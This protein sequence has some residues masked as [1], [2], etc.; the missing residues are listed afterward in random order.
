[1]DP[2]ADVV[3]LGGGLFGSALAYH[4]AE[5]T[6]LRVTLY[7][8]GS[9]RSATS[10]AAGILTTVGWDPWD[11][12]LVRYSAA[13]IAAVDRSLG[14]AAFRRAGGLRLSRT[15]AGS[16]WLDRVHALLAAE[17][18]SARLLGPSEV[19]DLAP[20]VDVDAVRSGLVTPDDATFDAAGAAQ[21]YRRLAERLGAEVVGDGAARITHDGA[22]WVVDTPQGA[23]VAPR[24][25]VACGAETKALLVTAG[26]PLPVAPFRSQ[27]AV[28]RPRPLS[29]SFPTLHDLDLEL[30]VREAPCG[31]VL[32]GNGTERR[33]TDPRTAALDADAEWLADLSARLSAIVPTWDH[34]VTERSWAGC[35]V[36]SPDRFP[37]VGRIPGAP[38]LL[39]ATGF[40]GLGAMRAPALARLLAEAIAED[41]WEP[42]LPADPARF[43]DGSTVADVR[44]E[45]P[46]E[47]EPPAPSSPK[48][49][50]PVEGWFDIDAHAAHAFRTRRLAG[51]PDLEVQRFPPLS[52]WFDPF[53]E[54]F[55]L[56][57]LRT[58]GEVVLAEDAESMAGLYLYSPAEG[59]GSVFT[60]RRAVALAFLARP[61]PGG[62]YADRAW[63]AGGEPIEVMAADL[64]DWS[65]SHPYRNPVR[66]AGRDDLARVQRLMQELTG[67]IDNAWFATLPRPEEL[68]FLAEVDGRIAGMS[69]STVVGEHAR[70]HS[71]M[72]H[73]RYR[74]LGIGTD[75]LQARMAWLRAHGVRQVVSEIYEGNAA[76]KTAAERAGMASVGR[77]FHYRPVLAT[78]LAR[79]RRAR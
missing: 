13:E 49:Q 25:A 14:R 9:G 32:A 35:C 2:R 5:R 78:A 43:S 3:V 24:L 8:A 74:G 64:R 17:G 76:S 60:Q 1:M 16:A 77:M 7:D 56:D 62:I 10:R 67:A 18:V 44:P 70:G 11:I 72:V 65:P 37:L 55:A 33:E 79:A 75:L 66:I 27:A 69:W 57:A 48:E 54:L 26:I 51:V 28:L 53:L 71:F 30:Y 20:G 45:F 47:A 58:G 52:E 41:R 39:V 38:G 34:L 19:A 61:P 4:L 31:R 22:R 40:N 36:A 29:G 68:C 23:V 21:G 50:G 42:L 63:T 15:E 46:L 6:H 73:P 12:G 59:V